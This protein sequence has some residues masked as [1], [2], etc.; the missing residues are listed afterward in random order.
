MN[1]GV[2]CR[3]APVQCVQMFDLLASIRTGLQGLA[4]EFEPTTLTGEQSLRAVEE[5]GVIRRLTD[6]MLAKAAKRV[7]DTS[8]HEGNGD[9]D[10]AP[11][12]ARAVGVEAS[13]ARRVIDTAKRL[14]RLPE[15]A[16]AV[17]EGRLSGRQAQLVA[18]AA[19]HN[20]AL[21]QE[22]LAAAGE[23]MV[24]LKDACVIARARAEG[25]AARA[26]RLLAARRM[27]MWT[28]ADG[29]VEGHFA[30]VSRR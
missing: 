7:A 3:T 5:L 20:P 25:E 26:A 9:R 27:R 1:R 19:A 16:A 15:T 14:E 11:F 6:G 4:R 22:L 13:E 23:G 8:A 30:L 2:E 21:E 29:M 17:S 12:Y 24:P 18:E 10:A 28:A